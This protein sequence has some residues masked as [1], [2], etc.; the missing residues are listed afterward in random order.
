MPER[1]MKEREG[2]MKAILRIYRVER[3]RKI[4][5]REEKLNTFTNNFVKFLAYSLMSLHADEETVQAMT[6]IDGSSQNVRLQGQAA[7]YLLNDTTGLDLPLYISIGSDNTP[8]SRDDYALKNLQMSAEASGPTITNGTIKYS[9]NFTPGTDI[10][11]REVGLSKVWR[12]AG[13]GSSYEFLL[14]RSVIS[15]FT[16]SAGTTYVVEITISLS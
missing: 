15:D 9:A 6:A 12:E 13:A 14:L 11:V 8:A 10:T 7:T 3:G 16:M 2:A 4:L 1:A 5:E